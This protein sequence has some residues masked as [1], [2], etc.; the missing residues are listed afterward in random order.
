MIKKPLQFFY[1]RAILSDVADRQQKN[2][3]IDRTLTMR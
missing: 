1:R 3:E 2:S